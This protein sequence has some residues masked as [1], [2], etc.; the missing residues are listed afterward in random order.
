MVKRNAK[1]N[2]VAEVFP[3]LYENVF[4]RNLKM[5]IITILTI[6]VRV[7]HGYYYNELSMKIEPM[8]YLQVKYGLKYRKMEIIDTQKS[9]ID[10]I[11][12]GYNRSAKIKY[13]N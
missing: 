6:I 13:N 10:F 11:T 5:R 7:G 9:T 8:I 12:P 4:Y 2:D 1:K 3:P